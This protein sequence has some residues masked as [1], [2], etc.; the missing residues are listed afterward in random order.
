MGIV[1]RLFDGYFDRKYSNVPVLLHGTNEA[2]LNRRIEETG[3]YNHPLKNRQ[4]TPV[5]L[6]P[7][8]DSAID[9]ALRRSLGRGETPIVLFIC[10]QDIRYK[11]KRVFLQPTVDFLTPDEFI[12]HF[13]GGDSVQDEIEKL[14]NRMK[15][16]DFT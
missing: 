15:K 13:V 5:Y 8:P 11:F 16:L 14:R 4:I 2:Y 7:H 12:V 10:T 1:K 3:E 9:Y 6:T